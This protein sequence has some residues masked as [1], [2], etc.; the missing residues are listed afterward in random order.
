MGAA[1]EVRNQHWLLFIYC[2]QV[3]YLVTLVVRPSKFFILKIDEF[4]QV[5]L[6]IGRFQ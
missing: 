6:A 5:A 2:L 1:L 4:Q 3:S